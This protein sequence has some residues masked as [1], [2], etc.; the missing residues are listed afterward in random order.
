VIV[1]IG[2]ED[3]FDPGLLREAD[4]VVHT[5][6][7][8]DTARPVAM[9][10]DHPALEPGSYH[11]PDFLPGVSFDVGEG[12]DGGHLIDEF[13]D[14]QRDG[15]L[16][17]FADP[18]FFIRA[19]G[20]HV[21]VGRLD[22]E[23]AAALMAE[24]IGLDPSTVR[25]DPATGWFRLEGEAGITADAFGANDGAFRVTDGDWVRFVLLDLDDDVVVELINIPGGLDEE[26]VA[27]AE[28]VLAT[29]RWG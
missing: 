12:W 17:G 16:V 5:V 14:V 26:Q 24:S 20:S 21:P 22:A 2:M 8:E 1:S 3:G 27:H 25:R 4:R 7:W 15:M 19:D 29:A 18:G 13:F 9:P 23:R 28:E 6:E 10:E 11:N